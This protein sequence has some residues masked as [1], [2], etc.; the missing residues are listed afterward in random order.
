[1]NRVSLLTLELYRKGLATTKEKRLVEKALAQDSRVAQRYKALQ[2]SDREIRQ[3]ISEEMRRL[4]IEER[5][6][7]P[8]KNRQAR[9]LVLAAAVLVCA[10]IPAIIYLRNG[11]KENA[12]AEVSVP[13]EETDFIPIEDILEIAVS[14]ELPTIQESPIER[15]AIVIAPEPEPVRQTPTTPSQT[16]TVP[17]TPI[18]PQTQTV[19]QTQT[20]NRP[21]SGIAEFEPSGVSIAAIPESSTGPVMR[22]GQTVEQANEQPGTAAVPEAQPNIN[23]PPTLS[24]IFDNMFANQNLSYVVI[25]TRVTSIGKN[26]FAGNP[27]TSITIGANVS[28]EDNAFPGNF[29]RAYNEY[30]R[31]AGTYTRPN[32]E[33]EEWGRIRD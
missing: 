26:A 21:E 25:P 5:P 28:I 30:G 16:Q 12:I 32:I 3:L 29:A 24:F 20:E 6:P 10:I 2:E 23:L 9:W 1:M 17:Q 14:P 18:A 19:P 13:E 11:P 31:S 27:L 7:A 4:N 22:G 15:T 33:S 8:Q